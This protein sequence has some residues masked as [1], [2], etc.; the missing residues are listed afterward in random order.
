MAFRAPPTPAQHAHP[1]PTRDKFAFHHLRPRKTMP[2]RR[3]TLA[4]QRP[5][6]RHEPVSPRLRSQGSGSNDDKMRHSP[7]N[8]ST[9]RRATRMGCPGPQY[10]STVFVARV[11]SRKPRIWFG[12]HPF[13]ACT[14]CFSNPA[15][16]GETRRLPHEKPAR[17]FRRL[18][19]P[20]RRSTCPTESN[21]KQYVSRR[22]N[23]PRCLHPSKPPK[24]VPPVSAVSSALFARAS[25]GLAPH[26]KRLRLSPE[27]RWAKIRPLQRPI[28]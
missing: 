10:W 20:P 17:D 2:F 21:R 12:R 28:F 5:S 14:Q 1:S 3:V 13:F 26:S 27:R 9:C 15:T 11:H 22:A 19:P 24:T 4:S 25:F 8:R 16:S 23:I 18:H 6:A 7:G